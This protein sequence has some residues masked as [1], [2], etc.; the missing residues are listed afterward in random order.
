MT[1]TTAAGP[2]RPQS[3]SQDSAGR[4]WR[5]RSGERACEEGARGS[6]ASKQREG[7]KSRS[8]DSRVDSKHRSF[9]RAPNRPTEHG[10]PALVHSPG[11]AAFTLLG[12]R[13]ARVSNK[14]NP[15][16]HPHSGGFPELKRPQRSP[17]PSGA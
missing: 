10:A 3:H 8:Y 11:G 9:P 12:N 1:H 2:G 16:P 6:G 17:P 5:K 14:A 13:V 4:I 15:T 7:E